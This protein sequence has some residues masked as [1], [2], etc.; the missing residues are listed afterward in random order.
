VDLYG[1]PP[2]KILYGEPP[3]KM[4]EFPQI[5]SEFCRGSHKNFLTKNSMKYGS[6]THQRT[7][8][9]DRAALLT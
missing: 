3:Y 2:Y 6:C 1:E 7:L 4:A 5:F 9:S 8:V